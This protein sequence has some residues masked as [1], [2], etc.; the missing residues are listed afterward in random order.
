MPTI[1]LLQNPVLLN[2]TASSTS[3][4]AST[5]STPLNSIINIKNKN[6]SETIPVKLSSSP[7]TIKTHL[8]NKNDFDNDQNQIHTPSLNLKNQIN[9]GSDSTFLV[10]TVSDANKTNSSNMNIT[11]RQL[12]DT[13]N[14]IA[15]D[16]N[17]LLVLNNAVNINTTP[18]LTTASNTTNQL[19]V[20]NTNETSTSCL[21]TPADL[22][23]NN[24][25][26][27]LL[28]GGTLIQSLNP[29]TLH[30]LQKSQI[31]NS[32]SLTFDSANTI[33]EQQTVLSNNVTGK[34]LEFENSKKISNLLR[35]S[36]L[37]STFNSKKNIK[38]LD[39]LRL[40]TFQNTSSNEVLTT[41][42]TQSSEQEINQQLT[43]HIQIP[44]ADLIKLLEIKVN[45][46]SK[47]N[48][49]DCRSSNNANDILLNLI[50]SLKSS[51]SLSSS[52]LQ[53]P[54]QAHTLQII[55][56]TDESYSN[57]ELKNLKEKDQIFPGN[58]I[59][60]NTPSKSSNHIKT[61][62]THKKNSNKISKI[63]EQNENLS[64]DSNEK[65]NENNISK[66]STQ[67]LPVTIQSTTSNLSNTIKNLTSSSNLVSNN[68]K[69][70]NSSNKIRHINQIDSKNNKSITSHQL[71]PQSQTKNV[72]QYLSSISS[73]NQSNQTNQ[74]VVSA[75]LGK[76]Y[77]LKSSRS[78]SIDQLIAAAF[79]TSSP[80]TT[81]SDSVTTQQEIS[82]NN[83]FIAPI[84]PTEGN[85]L[86]LASPSQ[87]SE[88]ITT[89]D[90]TNTANLIESEKKSFKG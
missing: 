43:S 62:L 30:P 41:L 35:C 50:E 6:T 29:I 10:N 67:V 34:N 31:I 64:H 80:T 61:A 33:T 17:N 39:Q 15:V 18:V 86:N 38:Q 72:N 73:N 52:V 59:N 57:D 16:N 3:S 12:S 37:N 82:K 7:P 81:S 49:L 9:D 4:S 45:N 44:N 5:S 27:G 66:D 24:S 76:S 19:Q 89:S 53:M 11:C 79:V 71:T 69:S 84:S 13:T 1:A 85:S 75:L 46:D 21:L 54:T 68:L 56:K 36:D 48:T 26:N 78:N 77:L 87:T 8:N 63:N 55:S 47:L 60:N 28:C 2:E 40:Q 58:D 74:P 88:T 20:I 90:S 70:T 65:V 14:I 22:K 23:V 25:N 32:G 42:S 51:Q 83:Q